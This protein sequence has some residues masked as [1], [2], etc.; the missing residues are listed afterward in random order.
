MVIFITAEFCVR[1]GNFLRLSNF[2]REKRDTKSNIFDIRT[3]KTNDCTFLENLIREA[4]C[5][6]S[7]MISYNPS[8]LKYSR[9]C[10]LSFIFTEIICS[11]RITVNRDY[12]CTGSIVRY[13]VLQERV[14][15][16]EVWSRC[17][18]S[19]PTWTHHPINFFRAHC[20]FW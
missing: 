5:P 1:S 12:L 10:V 9:R 3:S 6:A 4:S 20:W 16:L 17:F 15:V 8:C 11:F 18:V 14:D 13:Y 7:I 19:S 2:L